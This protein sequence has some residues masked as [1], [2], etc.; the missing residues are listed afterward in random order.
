MFYTGSTYEGLPVWWTT[1][2][3]SGRWR[4]AVDRNTLPSWDPWLFLDDDGR[5]YLYYGSSNEYPLKG[6]EV[7]RDDFHPVSKIHDLLMLHPDEH[8]WE[9]FGM[10]NDDTTTL[11]PFTEGAAMTK[12]NG[13][14]Y[15]QYG[16]PGTEFKTYADGVYV[17]DSPLDRLP[18]SVTTR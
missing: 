7:S 17:A 18:T 2:P 15:L 8:G 12:H 14:Y 13:R 3:K 6:V 11:P 9:R 1:D 5:L 4:R 10:N 16:A